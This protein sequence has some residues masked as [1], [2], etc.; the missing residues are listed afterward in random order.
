M[1]WGVSTQQKK[2]E[3]M[4]MYSFTS[5]TRIILLISTIAPLD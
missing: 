4:I 5:K 3:Y 2:K 1:K